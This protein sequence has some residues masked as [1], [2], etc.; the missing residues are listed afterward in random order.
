MSGLNIL[1][2]R[3]HHKIDLYNLIND[4]NGLIQ[5]PVKIL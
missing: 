5:N 4:I 1:I 3:L 2:Y